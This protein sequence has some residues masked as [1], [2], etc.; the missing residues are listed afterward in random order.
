MG[1]NGVGC[2]GGVCCACGSGVSEIQG[3]LGAGD[4]GSLVPVG[5]V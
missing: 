1:V 3:V 5:G 2:R 4:V